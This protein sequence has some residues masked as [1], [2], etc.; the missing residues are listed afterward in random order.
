MCGMMDELFSSKNP[1]FAGG[2]G[3]AVVASGLQLMRA[4]F[5]LPNILLTIFVFKII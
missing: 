2:F 4:G 3:L 5:I 1:V